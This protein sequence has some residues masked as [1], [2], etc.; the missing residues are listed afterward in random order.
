LSHVDAATILEAARQQAT[1]SVVGLWIAY[2]ALG[3]TESL[4]QVGEFL[5]GSA[6]PDA[7]QYDVLAQALNDS[8]VGLDLDH[9]VPYFDELASL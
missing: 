8:F 9:P 2:V 1:L 4:E 6:M 7:P 3:G 5:M